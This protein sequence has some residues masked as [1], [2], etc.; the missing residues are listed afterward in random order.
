MRSI[1]SPGGFVTPQCHLGCRSLWDV[2]QA[3]VTK[4]KGKEAGRGLARCVSRGFAIG[5]S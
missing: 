1:I 5:M 3:S 4:S 2:G